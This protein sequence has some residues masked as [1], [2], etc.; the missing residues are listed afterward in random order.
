MTAG[1]VIIIAVVGCPAAIALWAGW[2]DLFMFRKGRGRRA[3][4]K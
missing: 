2:P 3:W 1:E 4:P